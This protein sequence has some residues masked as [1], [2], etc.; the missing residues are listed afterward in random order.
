L[1]LLYPFFFAISIAVDLLWSL[2]FI[3]FFW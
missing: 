3:P 2:V 1:I